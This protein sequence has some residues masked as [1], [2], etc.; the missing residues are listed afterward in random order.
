M[1]VANNSL[2]QTYKPATK[3]NSLFIAQIFIELFF[4]DYLQI[5]YV[6][7]G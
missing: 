6:V 3:P 1:Y 5:F 7:V 2:N 4:V